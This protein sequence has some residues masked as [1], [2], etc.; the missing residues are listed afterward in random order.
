VGLPKGGINMFYIIWKNWDCCYTEYFTEKGDMALRLM[1]LIRKEEAN[2]N[3]VD[4]VMVSAGSEINYRYKVDDI[5]AIEQ[6]WIDGDIIVTSKLPE[7]EKVMKCP[8]C[9][10]AGKKGKSIKTFVESVYST[11]DHYTCNSCEKGFYI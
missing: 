8:K 9:G 4:I 2:E 11:L 6:L 5:N 10:K 1:K 7:K 3:G